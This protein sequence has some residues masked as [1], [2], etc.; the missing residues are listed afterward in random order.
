MNLVQH[1]DEIRAGATRG[2]KHVNTRVGETIGNLQFF[3]QH[4]VYARD[5]VF[6]DFSRRVPDSQ[7]LAQ[8]GIEGLQ[9]WFVE[10]LH[11]VAFFKTRKE[12]F[13]MYTVE[14]VARPIQYFDEIEWFQF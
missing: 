6:D 13:S 4:R 11:R 14:N 1:L 3:A 10:I 9:E 2:I 5:H 7:L 8:L 12:G